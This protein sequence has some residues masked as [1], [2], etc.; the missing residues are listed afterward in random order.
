[1]A[2]KFLAPPE[3]IPEKYMSWK[4]EMKFWEI[5]TPTKVE[6]RAPTVFLGLT[7]KAREAILEMDPDSLKKADGMTLL[8]EKL[9][10]L[11]LVDQNQAALQLYAKFE[12]YLRPVNASMFDF[13]IE[14]DR[15]VEQLKE[16]KISLPDA[17]L[18]YRALKSANISEENE[19][20]IMATVKDLN[21]K[22]MMSQIRKVENRNYL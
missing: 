12:K 14:F 11:F 8:Y 2:H 15:M 3:L 19:K 13:Q 17:V 10:S 6:V 5:A 1:M 9:D 18:A 4:K 22:D 21:V 7:G 16:Y 20:I